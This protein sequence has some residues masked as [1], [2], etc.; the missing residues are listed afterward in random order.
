M[1]N[2]M[3]TFILIKLKD[4]VCAA[5]SGLRPVPVETHAVLLNYVRYGAVLADDKGIHSPLRVEAHG[6][7]VRVYSDGTTLQSVS[8]Y[9]SLFLTQK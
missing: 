7:M 1:R 2:N 4:R 9:V 5:L 6:S 3:Q 8:N